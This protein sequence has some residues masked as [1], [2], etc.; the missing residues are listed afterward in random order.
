MIPVWEIVLRILGTVIVPM[1][2]TILAYLLN[3]KYKP[4]ARLPKIVQYL[5]LGTIFG[6]LSICGYYLGAPISFVNYLGETKFVTFG[7]TAFAPFISGLLFNWPV[8][9]IAGAIGALFR[10]LI[11]LNDVLSIAIVVAILVGTAFSIFL[12]KIVFRDEKP[13]WYHAALGCVF[14]ECFNNVM[15]FT[16]STQ[17][18]LESYQIVRYVDVA[19]IV[20]EIIS[21]ILIFVFIG[22]I[23]H[24]LHNHYGKHIYIKIQRGAF[25]LTFIALV[26][27]AGGSYS[28][29][30][31]RSGQDAITD[32]DSTLNGIYR[33]SLFIPKPNE[34]T[35]SSTS[36]N[37]WE[38]EIHD[39]M[40]SSLVE[41][42]HIQTSG[43][44]LVV[45]LEEKTIILDGGTINLHKG[46][47]VSCKKGAAKN[48][49]QA[50]EI[51]YRTLAQEKCSLYVNNGESIDSL[52]EKYAKPHL[53]DGTVQSEIFTLYFNHALEGNDKEY[54]ANIT[55]CDDDCHA[56][57]CAI[58][59]EEVRL[60]AGIAS[61]T[62]VYASADIFILLYVLLYIMIDRIVVSK[63]RQVN[64]S[65]AKIM[66]GDVNE[67]IE[68]KD[69][70]EFDELTTDINLAVGALKN[71]G[72][73]INRR[74]E[75]DLELARS[76]QYN[77]VPLIFP[78]END[79]EIYA[80]M[81]TAKEVG[82]DF[83]DYLKLK[84][85]RIMIL[86]ADVSGK[87]IPASLHMMRAKTL[88]KSLAHSIDRPEEILEQANN[89]LC[90]QN[91][92]GLFVTAWLGILNIKTGV[93]DYANAGHC[94]PIMRQNNTWN[95]VKGN[96][97][98]V[99]GGFSGLKY[100]PN[101]VKLEPGDMVLLYTDGV[102]EATS[103]AKELYGE[104]RLLKLA[105]D[106]GSTNPEVLVNKICEQVNLFQKGVD[107]FDDITMLSVRYFGNDHAERSRN[108][109]ISLPATI[110]N[111][112]TA[113]NFIE[114]T[115]AP[116]HLDRKIVG[117][118]SLAANEILDNVVAHA[119]PYHESKDAF[120]VK[121]KVDDSKVMIDFV[122][123]GL[124][125]DPTKMRIDENK[126]EGN[127]T[128][129][130]LVAK[131]NVDELVYHR[132]NGSNITTITKIYK[133][134]DN[135]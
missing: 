60:N 64:N 54:I 86:I 37:S 80:T 115:L 95:Y 16:I 46:T 107:Q 8:A 13:K 66:D 81:F 23:D 26:A 42:R 117:S 45:L 92:S 10:G 98:F 111:I 38:E 135:N 48:A 41:N 65:L 12:S 119:Y 1:V 78:Y 121:I 28:L 102:T 44:A 14:V 62:I 5:I 34:S 20:A 75:G 11:D 4:F 50:E 124:D 73:E 19:V 96:K 35:D 105:Q 63:I 61:R 79:Y 71:Y 130:L 113:I 31:N 85:D 110:G 97:N 18:V 21:S 131:Q 84:N 2:G 43:F 68:I 70:V 53:E 40:I 127:V 128:L 99:L 74:I 30:L 101:Q 29:M 122:D 134:A 25:I 22:L 15:I 133:L 32:L 106:M 104:P 89:E 57:I 47:V 129:G 6:G 114:F 132:D 52:L 88:I 112:S 125:F 72:E 56:I 33:D 82:G 27:L 39:A 87:G 76:I 91:K 109:E 49:I 77:A 3:K 108:G 59:V 120:Q 51:T 116:Y 94:L 58:T 36:T 90:E 55:K 67:H 126:G 100:K 17:T 83:Y 93:L 24:T 9:V 7:T 103:H 69:S 118:I 123:Q